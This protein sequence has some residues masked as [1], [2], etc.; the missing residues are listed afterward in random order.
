MSKQLPTIITIASVVAAIW[1]LRR[2]EKGEHYFMKH[3]FR[4]NGDLPRGYRN[5]NPLNIRYSRFNP[6]RGKIIPNA[7]KNNT[8]EQFADICYGYRAALSLLR[9]YIRKYGCDTVAKVIERWAPP[10]EN[11][12]QGYITDVCNIVGSS[13][14]THITP[15][16]ILAANDRE[17]LTQIA[18]AMS[19]I[20]NGNNKVTR[21]AGLP[22]ME[23]IKQGWEML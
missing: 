5:N 18:Y 1:L 14:D 12:T 11:N 15:D 2:G 16:T 7:D 8:F 17:R 3:D 6:W 9:T 20:E 22:D 13:F 21:E 23:F 10:T 19:I 4:L